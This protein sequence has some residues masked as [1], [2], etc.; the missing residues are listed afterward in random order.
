L[1]NNLKTSFLFFFFL[2]NCGENKALNNQHKEN[3]PFLFTA[4]VTAIKD[5]DTFKIL[6]KNNEI[7]VRLNH[8][9]C[10]EK[11]AFWHKS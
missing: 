9:D 10:P 3:Y 6:Y 8:I 5:G 1:K 4:K 11:T 7:T 2:I